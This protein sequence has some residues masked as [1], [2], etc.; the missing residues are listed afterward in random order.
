MY[1]LILKEEPWQ[2][3]E[4]LGLTWLVCPVWET[5]QVYIEPSL[6][7]LIMLLWKWGPLELALSFHPE[8]LGLSTAFSPLG[9]AWWN[10]PVKS[11]VKAHHRP[12]VQLLPKI[13]VLA[14]TPAILGAR[15]V[16]FTC[17][18]SAWHRNPT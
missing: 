6:L 2:M 15:P 7:G 16:L 18:H 11:K 17:S 14:P 10:H 8:A 4:P 1:L 9:W 3:T 13:P 12:F 5:K